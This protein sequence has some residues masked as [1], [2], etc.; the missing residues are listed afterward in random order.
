MPRPF[1]VIGFTVFFTIAVLFNSDIGAAV[2]V[3]V[4]YAVALIVSLVFKESREQRVLPCAFAS[5][6]LACILLIT[7]ISFYY[8]PSVEY[9]GKTC[10]TVVQLTDYPEFSYGNYYYDAKTVEIGGEKVEHKLRLVF[11]SLPDAE[12]YDLIDGNF[13]FYVLGSSSEEYLASNKAKG[14]FIGAYPHNGIYSVTNVPESDKPFMKT[15]VDARQLIK[16]SINKAVPGDGGS[17][18]TALVLGDKST[19]DSQILSDFRLSG[20]THI[21][22]VSG[23]HLSLWAMVILEILRFLKV[24]EKIASII[25]AVGVVAFMLVAG[26]TYSVLRAGI[27]MLLFL[28][29]NI[30]WKKRDS[31]NSLGFALTVIAV[32][33]P[34]AMGSVGLQLSALATLGLILYSRHIKPKIDTIIFKMD[35]EW[36]GQTLK[37]LINAVCVPIAA[38]SFT[39]PVS[40]GLYGE[41]NLAVFASNLVAVPVA[42]VCMVL[43]I[44]AAVIGYAVT[45]IFNIFAFAADFT[46]Q[47][48]LRISGFFGEFDLLT[49][50]AD[51]DSFKILF[52]GMFLVCAAAVFVAYAGENAYKI[53][54]AICAVMLVSCLAFSS[55]SREY[56]TRINV[57]DVGNGT[58]VLVSKNGENILIGCGG[59]DFLGA[60][61][62]SEEIIKYGG[63][64]DVLI[65]PEADEYSAS[66]LNDILM[67]FRPQSVF[68]GDLPSGSELLLG[69]SDICR[70]GNLT[71][72]DSFSFKACD[73]DYLYFENDDVSALICFDP[74]ADFSVFPDEIK[75][76]DVIV[77]RNDYPRNIE[78]RNCKLLVVNSEN[79]RGIMIQNEL[80]QAGVNCVA[81][82]GC[83]NILIRAEDGFVSANRTD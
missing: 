67:S 26:M 14:I 72:S 69:G 54:C 18:I 71:A 47:V 58:A 52:C 57:I 25:A 2:G 34:F 73:S 12:P 20:I 74:I 53:T 63:K 9:G 24:N 59:T 44:L 10:H 4:T 39:L 60:S 45:D 75:S 80:S 68:C 56:E 50:R 21:I 65:I 7:E 16:N 19:L 8:Q 3:L 31:L 83:G 51:D 37:T 64:T 5:G 32:Y 48:L 33:N 1:A 15:V 30:L 46:A 27:M 11:S 77:T 79:K 61:K 62:I 17:L 38:T 70:Y 13:T 42:S 6:M 35:N 81:T 22:C 78:S 43:G 49:F 40:I 36:L 23:F 29:A 76:A 66:Y 28:L 55:V 41:F 82:G